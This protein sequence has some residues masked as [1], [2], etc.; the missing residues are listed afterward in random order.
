MWRSLRDKE[1]SA[2][3]FGWDSASLDAEVD[4]IFFKHATGDDA[5]RTLSFGKG[6]RFEVEPR[7]EGCVLRVV[8]PAPTADPAAG[9]TEGPLGQGEGASSCRAMPPIAQG[10]GPERRCRFSQDG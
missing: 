10:G 1:R 9:S 3:W 6:A 7:G 4:Y 2:Q 8:R 5:T